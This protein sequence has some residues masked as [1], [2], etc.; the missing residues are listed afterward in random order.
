VVGGVG[1]RVQARTPLEKANGLG[2][3]RIVV[4]TGAPGTGGVESLP[5]E[6]RL[7]IAALGQQPM[8]FRRADAR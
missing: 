7:E 1:R 3:A 2:D 6:Q 5:E 8:Q 4:A